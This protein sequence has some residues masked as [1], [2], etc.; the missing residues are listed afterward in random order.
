MIINS[1]LDTDLYKYTMMQWVFHHYPTVDVEYHF[2]CRTPGIDLSPYAERIQQEI[3]AFC[4]RV[5]QADELDYLAQLPYIKPDFFAYLKTFRLSKN[6]IQ[7][8]TRP[9]FDI[10]IKGP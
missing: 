5:L 6:H 8:V 10:V 2:T 4:D 7:I 1:L 3:N 9:Q